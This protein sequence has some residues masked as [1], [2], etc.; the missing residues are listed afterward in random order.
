MTLNATALST[1]SMRTSM[2]GASKG[3]TLPGPDLFIANWTSN[4]IGNPG[5]ETWSTPTHPDRW[6]P[7]PSGDQYAWFATEPKWQVS[8]GTYSGGLQCR[9]PSGQ[10]ASTFWRQ[11]GLTAD[12]QNLNLT[13]DWY[14]DQNQYP[15]T[16]FYLMYLQLTNGT[17]WYA[18]Y[19]WLNGTSLWSNSTGNG[20][21]EISGPSQQWNRFSRNVTQ[22]FLDIP[23]FPG[24][25]SST[26]VCNSIYFLVNSLSATSEHL[27]GFV[28]DL[29]LENESFTWIGGPVRD[30]NFESG[31]PNFW[32]SSLPHCDAAQFSQSASAYSGNW[33]GNLTAQSYGNQSYCWLGSFPDCRITTQNPGILSFWWNLDHQH[34]ATGSQSYILMEFYN[35]SAYQYLYYLIGL[36]GTSS[37]ANTTTGLVILASG[38][39]T[40]GTWMYFERNI[41]DDAGAYFGTDELYIT[42]L[43][44]ETRA[45]AL[46]ARIV[47]LFDDVRLEAG[48][49]NGAGFEDQGA[50]GNPIR[51]LTNPFVEYNV[52]T[53]TDVASAGSK[54]ANLTILGASGIEFRQELNWRQLDSSHETYLDVMWRLEDFTSTSN[55]FAYIALNL[56]DFHNIRY[57]FAA[58]TMPANT[59]S[60]CYF[61]LTSA[62]SL[63]TWFQMHRDLVHDYEEAFGSLPDTEI[64]DLWIRGASGGGNRLE[65]LFDD[66]YLY[67]DPAPRLSNAFWDP[68][69][70]NYDETVIIE[71]DAE[72]Q[73]LDTVILYYEIHHDWHY[74]FMAPVSGNT[75]RATIPE[76]PHDTFVRFFFGATDTWGKTTL[77]NNFGNYWSYTV[78]DQSVPEVEITSPSDHAVI[79]ETVDITVVANDWGSGIA[80]VE[81]LVNDESLFVDTSAPFT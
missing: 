29:Y 47:T 45:R 51:G 6:D 62:N 79:G 1:Q 66:L 67:D 26:L 58:Q 39:N 73:D 77:F 41:W 64:T 11:S 4:R 78:W 80:N 30:G 27:R 65:I 53:V 69:T 12:M 3:A 42:Y 44:I 40:T 57:Y 71:V 48:A 61:N 8:Q 23:T 56:D 49:V 43:S 81:I 76:Q 18:L 34:A 31:I 2:I 50:V 35:G 72:D 16:N 21:I 63:N 14:L 19:Y 25:V 9:S 5:F 74:A 15:A 22:D 20:V 10:Y 46:D 13:F 36:A 55:D 32:Q 28:D 52:F 17:N 75:Y 33:C 7:A 59:S 24:S 60:N 38:F 54:S 68:I 70:P 37:W